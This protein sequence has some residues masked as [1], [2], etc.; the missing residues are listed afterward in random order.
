MPT[1][2]EVIDDAIKRGVDYVRS[3]HITPAVAQECARRWLLDEARDHERA[4][5]RRVEQEALRA[6]AVL[7]RPRDWRR[8]F[9]DWVQTVPT[10]SLPFVSTAGA[11]SVKPLDM[12]AEGADWGQG[13]RAQGFWREGRLDEA[14]EALTRH[15][16]MKRERNNDSKRNGWNKTLSR[17]DA[18]IEE[19]AAELDIG[20]TAALLTTTV[21]MPDGARVPW[22]EATIEQHRARLDMLTKHAASE[23]DAATRHKAAIDAIA[24][25]PGARCLNDTVKAAA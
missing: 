12:W 24:A 11:E 14:A 8:E 25:T 15:A 9:Y 19:R 17:L 10:E 13:G 4:Q 18:I 2:E 16:R 3:M 23:V 21:A 1:P 7:P 6:V 5:A 22:G 20:W